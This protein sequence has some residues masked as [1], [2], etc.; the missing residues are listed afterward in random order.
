MYLARVPL[1]NIQLIIMGSRSI[2]Y[3]HLIIIIIIIISDYYYY[4]LLLLQ[5]LACKL[6]AQVIS[7]NIFSGPSLIRSGAD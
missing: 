5:Y 6:P 2:Y 3:Y 4:Q 1:L 7:S